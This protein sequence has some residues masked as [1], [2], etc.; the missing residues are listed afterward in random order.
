MAADD[1]GSDF[2]FLHV[3]ADRRGELDALRDRGGLVLELVRRGV[4]HGAL[5]VGDRPPTPTR[6]PLAAW[7]A[8]EPV[9]LPDLLTERVATH[10]QAIDD[11]QRMFD[12]L[13]DGARFLDEIDARLGDD[14]LFR[15]AGSTV[16]HGE[17][18]EIE[19][20]FVDVQSEA[21]ARRLARDL[22]LKLSWIAHDERDL[23]L[24]I[25]VSFGHEATRD[26]LTPDGREEWSDRLADAVFP[27]CA[28]VTGSGAL[29]GLL[30]DALGGPFRLS[31]RIVYSNAPGGGAL[32]HHDADPGQRGVV[33]AQLA[34]VTVWLA[35]PL[36][37]LAE[38]VA[39]HCHSRAA[40]VR[41]ALLAPEPPDGALWQTLNADPSFTA[42][43]VRAGHLYAL[44]P[45]DALLLPSHGPDDCVW[46]SVFGTG[47]APSLAHSDGV[48]AG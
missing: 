18:R 24:R 20:L 44:G 35:L 21:G 22:W 15:Y 4:D 29:T 32:F 1:A 23:S 40:D 7:R 14:E 42:A 28:V 39:D 10:A 5:V 38:R 36:R 17:P 48:F 16:D 31:E 25:R 33:F 43:L 12:R 45:G 26:W 11:T 2:D 13:R 3:T 19:K 37:E 8:G 41:S 46:H 34:G 6:D 27:E 47:D 30:R 9:F